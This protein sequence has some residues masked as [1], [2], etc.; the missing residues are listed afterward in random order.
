M[1][2]GLNHII[3]TKY[4]I[5]IQQQTAAISADMTLLPLQ[6]NVFYILPKSSREVEQT[7]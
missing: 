7:P 3:G 4:F 6:Y 1:G 5:K 2:W